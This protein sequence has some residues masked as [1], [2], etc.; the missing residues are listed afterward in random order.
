MSE[1]NLQKENH[2]EATLSQAGDCRGR[3]LANAYMP[4]QRDK[5]GQ[6]CMKLLQEGVKTLGFR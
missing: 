2:N 6:A 1:A 4:R 5:E 3:R